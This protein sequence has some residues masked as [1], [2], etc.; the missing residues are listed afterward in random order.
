[1][2]F[3]LLLQGVAMEVNGVLPISAN[4][5]Q[6]GHPVASANQEGGDAAAFAALLYLILGTPQAGISSTDPEEAKAGE[7]EASASGGV[8]S[9]K[10]SGALS[11]A[12]GE[13]NDPRAFLANDIFA[14]PA[15]VA[16]AGA[17]PTPMLKELA[18]S[19]AK[20][21]GVFTDGSTLMAAVV[22]G[23]RDASIGGSQ[24][25]P[26]AVSGIN[27]D[28]IEALDAAGTVPQAEPAQSYEQPVPTG[29]TV[30]R[31]SAVNSETGTAKV[32][33][34]TTA[35]STGQVVA[36]GNL[37][38]HKLGGQFQVEIT[39]DTPA[40]NSQA[41]SAQDFEKPATGTSNVIRLVHRAGKDSTRAEVESVAGPA[42]E[43]N[44]GVE[45]A[46]KFQFGK[47]A[48]GDVAEHEARL[49]AEADT[50]ADAPPAGRGPAQRLSDIAAP[51]PRPDIAAEK[52]G[53]AGDP[54][55][56][57]WRPTIERIAGELA[58]QVKLN[59]R[60]A[61][62]QLDPPELGKIKIDLRIEGDKLEARIVAEVHESRV[63]IESHLQE[64]RQSLRFQHV[65]L[66]DVRVSQDGWSGGS[67]DPM[68]GFRQQQPD[69]EPQWAR[70]SENSAA[71]A[72]ASPERSG[73]E[74]SAGGIGRVSVWA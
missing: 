28:P 65:D 24:A 67:G 54:A 41:T 60:E 74:D 55:P 50:K 46:G 52:F 32:E 13:P 22:A 45:S 23:N 15:E 64:L 34:P 33:Q 18:A 66:A 12:N 73:S 62:I 68:Q 58:S 35:G 53:P 21:D 25:E 29:G 39:A 1:V 4:P 16:A 51:M 9:Q 40:I 57:S 31:A 11:I 72:S 5:V 6:E 8:P 70:D 71:A 3:L 48:D 47:T 37:S 44:A 27:Q 42:G 7:T 43:I 59:K 63:L 38:N 30:G 56:A 2:A 36:S 17:A 19:G 20:F 10:G 69:G 14:P 49:V 61:V 26:G